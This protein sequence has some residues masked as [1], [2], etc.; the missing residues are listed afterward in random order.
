MTAS[1]NKLERIAIGLVLCFALLMFF[2]PFV[3]VRGP[4]GDQLG[5]GYHVRAT[6]TV[7]RSGLGTVATV[8]SS[9][10]R[11]AST[12]SVTETPTIAKPVPIP[13][14]LKIAPFTAWL[15]FAALACAALALLDFIFFQKAFATLSLAGGCFGAV[16]VLHVMLMG[17]D[18]GSW[19]TQFISGGL[20]SSPDS[21]LLVM[22][23]LLVNSFHVS[24]GPGLLVLTT[25]LFLVP[26]LSYTRATP[27]IRSIIRSEPR[28]NVSQPIRVRPLNSSYPEETGTSVNLSRSGLLVE[29]ASN[30]YYVGMEVYV[31]RNAHPGDL[32]NPEEHGSVV[33]VEKLEGGKCR[34]AIRIISAV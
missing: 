26:F 21:P 14:S 1:N 9:Q 13:F 6:L 25:C 34:I 7:L 16:A 23:M 29:S 10:D 17:S 33:R 18:L 15:I 30:R 31:T 8:K 32:T 20:L 22:R 2:F 28:V 12:R 11:G 4:G 5:D 27:R 19:T 3:S 24:P